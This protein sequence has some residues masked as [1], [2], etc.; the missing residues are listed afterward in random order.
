MKLYKFTQ[1][2][3]PVLVNLDNACVIVKH[4]NLMIYFAGEDKNA[5]DIDQSF[6]EV[7]RCLERNGE[8][9]RCIEDEIV[10]SKLPY[11]TPLESID[12]SNRARHILRRCELETIADLLAYFAH[13]D[14]FKFTHGCGETT[15]MEIQR[16]MNECGYHFIWER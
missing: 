10:E 2:G 12:F 1:C 5:I 14:K 9:I 16:R 4:E 7:V 15:I 11:D 6:D 3:R 8:K 13:K